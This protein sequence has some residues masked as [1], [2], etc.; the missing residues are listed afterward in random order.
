[1]R[2][3]K[4]WLPSPDG[5]PNL[6]RIGGQG[7][8]AFGLSSAAPLSLRPWTHPARLETNRDGTRSPSPMRLAFSYGMPESVKRYAKG[9][10]L[11]QREDSK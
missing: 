1:M 6:V 3:Q 5:E 7:R 8:R 9:A 11:A 4:R 2:S 10:R